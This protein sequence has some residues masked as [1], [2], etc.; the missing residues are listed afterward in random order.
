M[1]RY[2]FWDSLSQSNQHFICAEPL[3]ARCQSNSTKLTELI[4]EMYLNMGGN[5]LDYFETKEKK[6]T[7]CKRLEI[8][9]RQTRVNT[10]LWIL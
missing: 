4:S 9:V 7:G 5:L 10:C 2:S 8:S 6:I 1:T 3:S